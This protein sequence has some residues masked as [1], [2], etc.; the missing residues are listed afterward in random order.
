MLQ[1][2]NIGITD[3]TEARKT[4]ISEEEAWDILRQARPLVVGK[5]KKILVFD[6]QRDEQEHILKNCLGRTGNLRAPTLRIGELV[7]VGFND[8]MYEQYL[9]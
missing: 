7:L 9:E 1:T 5:G 8:A 6:P 4:K 2:K 3:T